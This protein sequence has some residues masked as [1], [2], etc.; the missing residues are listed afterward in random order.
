[1]MLPYTEVPCGNLELKRGTAITCYGKLR[2]RNVAL[3]NDSINV[4][5]KAMMHDFVSAPCSNGLL[6]KN[7]TI[8]DS[9]KHRLQI[10]LGMVQAYVHQTI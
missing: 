8:F 1:M 6:H 5:N 3:Y 7:S 2:S 4:H 9:A 10:M